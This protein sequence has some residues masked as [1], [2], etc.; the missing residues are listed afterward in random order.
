[1]FLLISV[2]LVI[3]PVVVARVGKGFGVGML[4]AGVVV[5]WE[6]EGLEQEVGV[7]QAELGG[8]PGRDGSVSR[9]M[10]RL[11][12]RSHSKLSAAVWF[13]GSSLGGVRRKED[14]GGGDKKR[15]LLFVDYPAG[16]VLEFLVAW[17]VAV[18]VVGRH[19]GGDEFPELAGEALVA[20]GVVQIVA[21]RVVS[22]CS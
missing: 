22:R 9:P 17:D 10:S 7:D 12:R 19:S 13:Q 16:L 3:E 15:G 11:K 6:G 4:M 20:V 8:R 5:L 18:G 2:V 21:A 14:W 1:M